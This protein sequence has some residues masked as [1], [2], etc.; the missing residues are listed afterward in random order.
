MADA[1]QGRGNRKA[2]RGKTAQGSVVVDLDIGPV[3]QTEA[4]TLRQ[5]GGHP[6]R[7]GKLYPEVEK[8]ILAAGHVHDFGRAACWCRHEPARVVPKDGGRHQDGPVKLAR[9][10]VRKRGQ[11]NRRTHAVGQRGDPSGRVD[12]P[13]QPDQAGKFTRS[14]LNPAGC[15]PD[16]AARIPRKPY[17]KG[18][19]PVC[20]RLVR[21]ETQMPG[22][23]LVLP[24]R[25]LARIYE[26]SGIAAGMGWRVPIAVNEYD[27]RCQRRETGKLP[28]DC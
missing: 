11:H 9:L 23:G 8:I 19:R 25:A 22:P 28:R 24:A 5:A 26:V 3:R 12:P 7:Q 1:G 27:D 21:P 15:L 14:L 2:K 13:D 10:Q 20:A 18:G 16:R 17:D 6:A 4:D